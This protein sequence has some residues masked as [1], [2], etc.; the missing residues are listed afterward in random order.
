M[1]IFRQKIKAPKWQKALDKIDKK[2]D[3]NKKNINKR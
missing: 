1:R 2:V 3:A